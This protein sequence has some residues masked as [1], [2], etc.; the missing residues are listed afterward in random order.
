MCLKR[1]YCLFH[2]FKQSLETTLLDLLTRNLHS[3]VVELSL[4]KES[5]D[6][7]ISE[8]GR[9]EK[10]GNQTETMKTAPQSGEISMRTD[11]ESEVETTSDCAR[12]TKFAD[13]LKSVSTNFLFYIS[14]QKLFCWSSSVQKSRGTFILGFRSFT[15]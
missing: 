7:I 6:S 12:C 10:I 5:I 15:K 11:G 14:L 2:V 4:L 9:I 3:L 1:V 8:V 13:F